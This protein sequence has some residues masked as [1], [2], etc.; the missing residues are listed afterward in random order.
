MWLRLGRGKVDGK[1]SNGNLEKLLRGK[2]KKRGVP[3]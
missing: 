3:F 1:G 2:E